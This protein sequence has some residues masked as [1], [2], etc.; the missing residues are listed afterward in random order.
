M[1]EAADGQ[2][3][4]LWIACTNP[5][6][7]LPDQAM[8][9]RAL[10]RAEFV[11]VQEAFATTATAPTPTCC[12]PPPPGARTA[13]SPTASAAS[14]VRA[15]VPARRPGPPRLGDRHADRAAL[16]ARLRP[17]QPS[18]FAYDTQRQQAP[19]H[20]ERAPRSTRGRDLDITGLSWPCWNRRPAAM[21]L[22]AG[23]QAGGTPV[24][25][26]RLSHR[27]RPRPLCRPAH[28]PAEPRSARYPFS[29]NTGRLRDQWHGMSRTGQLGRL[30]AHQ[31]EP[32]LH[33]HPQDM[34][35]AA[36]RTATWWRCAAAA[37][38]SC[39]RCRPNRPGPVPGLP[40]HAL[41]QRVPERRTPT[42]Q[43]VG[44]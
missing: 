20:L 24:R 12:C 17:G 30:F 9:R 26:R 19:S 28:R 13:P 29:L 3:K 25:R 5:A 14:R 31:S 34:E 42:G 1:F 37:A 16:E 21:A 10:E 27:R 22:P 44:A 38:P 33:M 7:S 6:Q 43:A 11:V 15:A 36:C 41:G 39:C 4:A 23:A 18:L 8:V 2:I 40:A 32:V 35:R